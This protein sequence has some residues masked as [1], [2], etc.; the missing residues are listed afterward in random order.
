MGLFRCVC[1]FLLTLHLVHGSLELFPTGWSTSPL[2]FDR[3]ADMAT[4]TNN[5][6]HMVFITLAGTTSHLTYVTW[7]QISFTTVE[8]QTF[9]GTTYSPGAPTI[10]VNNL[11]MVHIV[12]IDVQDVNNQI[13]R[14][15]SYDGAIWGE[16]VADT[17]PSFACPTIAVSPSGVV[18]VI[19]ATTNC[20]W[21]NTFDGATWGAVP[22]NVNACSG[23]HYLPILLMILMVFLTRFGPKVFPSTIPMMVL[24]GIM[25]TFIRFHLMEL[26]FLVM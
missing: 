16:H 22:I 5:N 14:H 7:N 12:F 9:G 15:F 19:Y 11:G 24:D 4:D 18:G 13:I 23:S 26:M 25:Q 17:N 8:L 21:Y 20:I 3:V 1:L 10:A 6:L 2:G